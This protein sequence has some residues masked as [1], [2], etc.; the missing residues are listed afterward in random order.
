VRAAA[1][2]T[3]LRVAV[4]LEL[5]PERIDLVGFVLQSA[6]FGSLLALGLAVALGVEEGPYSQYGT[7]AGAYVGL[8]V[9]LM[10]SLGS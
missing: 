2:S 4:T 9:F 1:L 5:V 10:L 8:V 6:G 7:L 3:G